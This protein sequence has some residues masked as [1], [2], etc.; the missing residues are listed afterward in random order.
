MKK[1]YTS[2]ILT[3]LN[4]TEEKRAAKI[5]QNVNEITQ[6]KKSYPQIR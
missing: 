1:L 6:K 3:D 2:R 5:K 4:Q